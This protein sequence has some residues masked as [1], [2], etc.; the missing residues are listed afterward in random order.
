MS[1]EQSVEDVQT[2]LS[3]LA[4]YDWIDKRVAIRPDIT[5]EVDEIPHH[6]DMI[7]LSTRLFE[8]AN[9]RYLSDYNGEYVFRYNPMMNPEKEE[10][11]RELVEWLRKEGGNKDSI[12][13]WV[14][15]DKL[16]AVLDE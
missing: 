4:E 12:G 8:E 7:E 9:Y 11:L 14:A 10:E 6:K 13:Y 1:E 2:A 3:I 15:A 16:E 5:A